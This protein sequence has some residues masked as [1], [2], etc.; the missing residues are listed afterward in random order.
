MLVWRRSRCRWFE[1][2]ARFIT[3]SIHEDEK[4]ILSTVYALVI[5]FV[6]C[7]PQ[8][9][10]QELDRSRVVQD[11]QDGQMSLFGHDVVA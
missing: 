10:L 8:D 4:D 9:Y 6:Q 1:G 2:R 5:M 11:T 3:Q 7:L